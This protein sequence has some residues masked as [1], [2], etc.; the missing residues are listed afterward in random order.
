MKVGIRLKD[1][2]SKR[3]LLL[4]VPHI[5]EPLISQPI[6]ICQDEYE[7][8][9]GL[10]LADASD[11]QSGLCIDVFIGLDSYWEIVTGE[12]RRGS[13]GPIAIHTHLGWV[14]LGPVTFFSLYLDT[15]SLVTHTLRV[16][17][18]PQ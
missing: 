8:L 10:E 6:S 12:T 18:V 16:D 4:S 7:H 3:L 14:L 9:K 2:Q 17:T 1:G 11:G 5:C 15:A 13:G